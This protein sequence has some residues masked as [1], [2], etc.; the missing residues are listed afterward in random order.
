MSHGIHANSTCNSV[1]GASSVSSGS[2]VHEFT[3]AH[4]SENKLRKLLPEVGDVA[5]GSAEVKGRVMA[6]ELVMAPRSSEDYL[7][8][9]TCSSAL[10]IAVRT[11]R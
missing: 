1:D 3:P 6:G 8:Q 4:C 5:K 7:E 10:P 11:E 2:R 9:A